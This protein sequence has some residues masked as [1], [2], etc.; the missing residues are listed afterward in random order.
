MPDNKS[1]FNFDSSNLITYIFNRRKPIIIIVAVAIIVSGIISFLIESKFESTVIV[2]PA[3]STSI[4]QELLNNNLIEK[5]ILKFG[6]EEE[7]EQLIQVLNSDEIREKIIIKYN[8]AEHYQ[9]DP[10]SYYPRTLLIKEYKDNVTIS[11][12]EYMSVEIEV[13]DKDPEISAMIA[14]DIAEYLDTVMNRMQKE[15]AFKALKIVESEYNSLKEHIAVLEDSLLDIRRM[16]I[17]DY[18]SQ[19]EVFNDA[20]AIAI[21][22]GRIDGAKKIEEKL[23][24]LAEYGGIY[25]NLRNLL[26]YEIEKVSILES[27]YRE[28]KVDLE[29]DLPHKFVVNNAQVAEKKSYPIRWLIVTISTLASFILTILLMIIFDNIKKKSLKS[30]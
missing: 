21:A 17:F 24:L 29:Q 25:S 23:K 10:K 16:G 22:E 27:K 11:R 6:D 13:L 18:E 9:I 1:D 2:F 5:N 7:V 30:I 12:T 4:S 19:S 8:L 3:N 20:Y 14:N 28:A 15:R 26:V